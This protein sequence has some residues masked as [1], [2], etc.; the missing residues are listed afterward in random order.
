MNAPDLETA[1]RLLSDAAE[2]GEWLTELPPAS[3]PPSIPE[4]LAMQEVLVQRLG[5]PV[6]GWKVVTDAPSGLSMWGAMFARDC[7]ANP[8]KVDGTMYSPMGVEGEIAFRFDRP[9]ER[10]AEPYSR[11]EIEAVLTAFPAI[12]IVS[13]RFVS[14][15]DTPPLDRVADRMSN[16]GLVIGEARPDWR[17]MDLSKL[18][19]TLTCDGVDILDRVGGHMRGDPMLPVVEFI[20]TVQAEKSFAVGE[21]ITAGTLTD[22]TFAKPGQHYT[23]EFHGF[24]RVELTFRNTVGNG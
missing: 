5:G 18:R 19:V 17:D 21:L 15:Q 6:A 2:S 14:Y 10:R 13:S 9:L 11:S 22:L 3:K 7:F 20:H 12:E 16:G 8:A 1:I 24:G 23:V 4:A